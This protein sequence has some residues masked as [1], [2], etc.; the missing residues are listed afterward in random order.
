MSNRQ[1]RPAVKCVKNFTN[2][3]AW[4]KRFREMG[5]KGEAARSLNDAARWRKQ[6]AWWKSTKVAV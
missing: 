5:M 6:V 4:A 3:L 1:S 2:A